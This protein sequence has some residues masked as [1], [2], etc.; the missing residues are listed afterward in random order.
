MLDNIL[1]RTDKFK[2]YLDTK[3]TRSIRR[4]NKLKEVLRNANSNFSEKVILNKGV[5][6]IDDYVFANCEKL[7]EIRIPETVGMIADHAF[8]GC[9]NLKII[10]DKNSEAYLFAKKHHIPVKTLTWD[11]MRK[12]IHKVGRKIKK[13]MKSGKKK[14]GV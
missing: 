8:D 9:A 14:S 6:H 3:D 2:I 7:K 4:I 10:C 5:V 1:T 13:S 12:Y 11:Y